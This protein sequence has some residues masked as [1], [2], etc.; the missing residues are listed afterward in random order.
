MKCPKCGY[1][2]EGAMPEGPKRP[3]GLA[4]IR[5]TFGEPGEVPLAK[6]VVPDEFKRLPY[7]AKGTITCHKLLA[8]LVSWIFSEIS[9]R[10]LGAGIKSYD[11]C[12]NP[13]FMRGSKS[14]WSTHAWAIALDI[15]AGENMPGMKNKIDSRIIGIFEQAGFYQLKNDPM[16]FQYCTGY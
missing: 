9:R 10:G 7:V 13:R 11:G 15:N 3:N 8:P 12:Y 2:D 16:H 5:A 4:A 1:T 6:A 14:R